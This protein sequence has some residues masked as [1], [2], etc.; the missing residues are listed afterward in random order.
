MRLPRIYVIDYPSTA[1]LVLPMQHYSSA[2]EYD[3]SLGDDHDATLTNMVANDLTITPGEGRWVTSRP[4]KSGYEF[5]GAATILTKGGYQPLDNVTALTIECWFI[6][7][8][9]SGSYRLISQYVDAT[10][11]AELRQSDND[12]IAS[13]GDGTDAAF[14]VPANVLTA[15]GELYHLV[16][17]W[18]KDDN[19]GKVTCYVDNV[20][21]NGANTA[22]DPIDATVDLFIGSRNDASHYFPGVICKVALYSSKLTAAN[23]ETLYNREATVIEGNTLLGMWELRAQTGTTAFDGFQRRDAL[24]VRA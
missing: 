4:F 20:V 18:D 12:I 7:S 1:K 2:T 19:G 17:V 23:V 9:L 16:M 14:A 6:P 24:Y 8:T 3:M 5:D 10:H 11:H 13:V 21:Y 22:T 15:A